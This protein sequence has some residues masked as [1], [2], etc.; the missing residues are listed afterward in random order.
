MDLAST[1]TRSVANHPFPLAPAVLRVAAIVYAVMAFCSA[2][3]FTHPKLRRPGGRSIRQAINSWWP[4]AI[5]TGIAAAL[6]PIAALPL[7]AGVSAWALSEYLRMLPEG[8]RPAG[9]TALA[10]MAVPVHY[11]AIASGRPDLASGSLLSFWAFLLMPLAR[12]LRHGPAGLVA[13][14]ARVGFGIVLSVFAIGYVARLFLLPASVGPAGP[15]GLAVLLLLCV[16]ANDASQFVAG[17]L[18]GKHR[19]APVISPKKTWEGLAGGMIVTALIAAAVA[20]KV[21]PFDAPRGALIG[22]SLSLVGL[23]GDLLVSAIKRDVGVKDSGDVLPGQ[24][25]VLDR[26][27][28]LLLAAPLYYH[29][30]AS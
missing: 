3:G 17:K 11:A 23:L 8:D 9:T 15:E 19:L 20:P 14:A 29:L 5:L 6:G 22:A 7:F 21:T 12:A 1:L 2:V 25:G 27:D 28:S 26:T 18:A 4:P 24:G 13:G 30:V 16:M 10:F